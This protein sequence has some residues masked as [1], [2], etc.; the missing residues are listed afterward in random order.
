LVLIG[1]GL[2]L[3]MNR[4]HFLVGASALLLALATGCGSSDD[5]TDKNPIVTAGMGGTPPAGLGGTVPPPPPPA[6][7]TLAPPVGGNA[8]TGTVVPP[9]TT[10][11]SGGA[12]AGGGGGGT[13]GMTP[14]PDAGPMMTDSGMMMGAGD[15]CPDGNCLCHGDVPT[16]LT[17]DDGPFMVDSFDMPSAGCVYYP[18]D[19]EP[20]FAAVAISDGA[21]GTGGCGRSQTSDWGPLY[22]SWGIVAMIIHTTGGDSPQA[23]GRKLTA[24]IESY[25]MEN[26]KSGSPLMGKLSGRYG[27]SGFSMGGGG[28]TY[29]AAADSTLKT[30]VS[31]MAWT[32]VSRGIT[33][34]SLYIIGASDGLAGTMG[35]S[36]YRGIA[37]TVPKMAITVRAGHVGQP[38]AGSGASGAVGLAF[39]KVFLEGDERWRPILLMADADETTIM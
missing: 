36:S 28:T 37:D 21:G 22:A 24:A 3:N 39:Q 27:T 35:M 9:S 15:C 2:V 31:I 18:T 29:S 32:P 5:G 4:E 12:V 25:K 34:P 33:V 30:S 8:G 20:P 14:A 38:S 6:G 16:A 1:E 10:A 13:A 26:M 19:A 17:S 7:G 11:G 23:R